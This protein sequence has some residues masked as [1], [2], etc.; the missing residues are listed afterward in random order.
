[1]VNELVNTGDTDPTPRDP[2]KEAASDS[3][4]QTENAFAAKHGY[5]YSVLSDEDKIAYE[6]AARQ[7]GLSEEI[8]L[9]RTRIFSMQAL[10]PF[11]FN[12]FARFIGLLE[13]LVRTNARLFHQE[14]E[15]DSEKKT[16][17]ISARLSPSFGVP[18]NRAMRRAMARA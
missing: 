12:M 18:M 14:H 2:G 5:Y 4:L 10:F 13:R 6:M 8:K 7:E 9:V 11:N 15:A 16:D 1:M 3:R 17:T